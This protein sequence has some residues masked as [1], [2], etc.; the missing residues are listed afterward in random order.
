MI[1]FVQD[2]ARWL[3]AGF[4][5]LFASTFGQTL[6]IG[7]SGGEIREAYGLSSGTFGTLYMLVTLSSA[8][9]LSVLGSV[10]DTRPLQTVVL[11]TVLILAAGAIIVGLSDS[12]LVLLIGLFLL[13]LFGQG[14][15]IH[16][17]FTAI[18]R[19]FKHSRGRATALSVLG[20]NAGEAILPIAFVVVASVYGW[21]AT[22][23]IIAVFLIVVTL[24]TSLALTKVDR[25]V[26]KAET[27]SPVDPERHWTRREVLRDPCF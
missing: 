16:T 8:A 3:A 25:P 12:L 18:G 17:A 27:V 19:W 5:L 11:W 22:W 9:V 23:L 26:S 7:L 13:R 10:L 14:M 1:R 24:P 15:I 21:Q 4:L 2:N 6:F 20:F